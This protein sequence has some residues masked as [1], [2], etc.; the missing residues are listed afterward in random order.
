M[1]HDRAA[2]R[3]P[4]VAWP[5]AAL[6]VL[7]PAAALVLVG[8]NASRMDGSRVGAYAVMAA[9]VVTYAGTGRLITSRLPGHV[10]GWLLGLIGLSLAAAMVTEQYALYGVATAPGSL[11]AARLAGWGSGAFV[12][13]AVTLLFSLVVLFPDGRLPSRRWRPVLWAVV[14]V[15]A[16]WGAQQLQAGTSISGGITN[17]LDAARAGYP[18]P[19]GV[20]P[21][22]GWFGG[23]IAATYALGVLTGMLVVASVF[24]RRHGAGTEQRKQLAWLGYV[25]VMTAVWLAFLLTDVIVTDG[26]DNWAASLGWVLMFLTP[27]AGI[28]LACA[29]AVLKYRLYDIDRIISRTLAYAI[30]TGL[31]VGVYA[32][33]V[34]LA[35]RV[36]PASHPVAVAGATLAAAALFSPLRSRVQRTV[37]RRFN[38]TRYDADQMVT[39]F[40]ARLKDA[41]DLD[42]VRQD[43]TGVVSRAL[44]PAHISVWVQPARPGPASAGTGD[45]KGHGLARRMA[46][47]SV[48][49]QP[50]QLPTS[51]GSVV[52]S[53]T[54]AR[55]FSTF[56]SLISS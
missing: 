21:R 25:G 24:V 1:G 27:V 34:L 11:P 46:S 54:R 53:R 10:I 3:A 17:A 19:L 15:A 26:G 41:V 22:H 30:V 12:A 18:N 20:F 28:P 4:A 47:Q 43:L 5:L 14:A 33:L 16:G 29:V 23:L 32:G 38:R 31:L 8:L 6:T 37:D 40:A 52:S 44:E 42:T 13:L 36:L 39:A 9:A 2:R 51:A 35:T 48:P 50:G 45:G 7:G 55:Y 56:A 49:G